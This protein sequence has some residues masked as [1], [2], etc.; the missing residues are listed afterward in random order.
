MASSPAVANGV[1]YIGDGNGKVYALNASTGTQIWNYTTE[2]SE[3]YEY[4][5]S[6]AVANGVVY[7]GSDDGK[8]YAL[9]ASTGTQIWNYTTKTLSI[10]SISPA[11]R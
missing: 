2:N 8:V 3:Y 6:P 10:M 1:V 7:V 4:I 11:L 5:T 9:N